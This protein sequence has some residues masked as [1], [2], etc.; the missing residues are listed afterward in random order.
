MV[1]NRIKSPQAWALAAVL[2]T[3]LAATSAQAVPVLDVT[4]SLS[5]PGV[6]TYTFMVSDIS[7][8]YKMT[9]SDLGLPAPF[10]FSTSA[11][12]L[13]GNVLATLIGSGSTIFSF[14]SAGEYGAVVSAFTGVGGGSYH[15]TISPVPEASTWALMLAGLALVGW[16]LRRNRTDQSTSQSTPTFAL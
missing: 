11:T 10:L 9:F 15:L 14:S 1:A 16:R 13:G 7:T 5:A 12:F 3:G 4:D 2:A 8:P 6:D